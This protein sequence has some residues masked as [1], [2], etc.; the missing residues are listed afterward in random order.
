MDT[1]ADAPY[2][3]CA[4]KLMEYAGRPRLKKSSDKATLPGRKQVF[5]QLNNGRIARD[6]VVIEGES[7]SGAALIK[8]VMERGRRTAPARNLND[9][10]TY[11]AEQL[12]SLPENLKKIG[13]APPSPVDISSALHELQTKTEAVLL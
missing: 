9:I 13:P 5:R 10:R 8:K 4:Y 7:V 1:S 12:A 11:T 3:E 6:V 2:L